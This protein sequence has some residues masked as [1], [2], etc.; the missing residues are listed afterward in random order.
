MKSNLIFYFLVILVCLDVS[1][2]Q[3][4]VLITGQIYSDSISLENIHVINKTSKKATISST[5]GIFEIPVKEN[6]ELLFSSIQFKNKIIIINDLNIKSLIVKIKLEKEVNSLDEVTIEKR[7]NIAGDLGLPNAGKKPLTKV[8]SR[9]NAHT[10][11]SLPVAVLLTLIGGAGGIDNLYYIISGDRKKDRK[12]TSLLQRDKNEEFKKEQRQNIRAHLTDSFFIKTLKI[13][14][15]E[16]DTFIQFC[17]SK[18]IDYLLSKNRKLE[19]IDIFIK[20]S[21]HFLKT[22]KD[23]K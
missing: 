14:V 9:L 3:K 21:P 5:N 12:L 10:K 6:D 19:V 20:E 2:Q 1:A 11:A 4:R 23:E 15:Q 8:E 22:L 16:I 17:D 7:R 18:N 13:P